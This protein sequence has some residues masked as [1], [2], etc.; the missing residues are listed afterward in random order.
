[1][2][3]L[4][5]VTLVCIVAAIGFYVAMARRDEPHL[6]MIGMMVLQVGAV[7]GTVYGAIAS[8]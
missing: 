2:V 8:F 1:M 6:G 4:L 5:V 7:F 3:V